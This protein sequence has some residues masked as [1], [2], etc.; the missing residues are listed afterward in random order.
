[1]YTWG[2]CPGTGHGE[3]LVNKPMLLQDLSSKNVVSARTCFHSAC[4][5]KARKVLTWGFVCC[6][7]LGHRDERVQ[8][9]PKRIEALVG[10]EVKQVSCGQLHTAVSNEDGHVYYT[11]GDGANGAL[12]HGEKETMTSP[13]LVQALEKHH[14]TQVQCG[15]YHT[16]ALTS[17]GMFA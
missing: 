11:F 9:S 6:G 15:E 2:Q 4:V 3:A 7:R 14:I 12:G 10:V 5:T 17:S 8:Y 13:V 1:M 16:M